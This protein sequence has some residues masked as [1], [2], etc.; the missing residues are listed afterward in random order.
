MACGYGRP[1]C[2][3]ETLLVVD[4]GGGTFDVSILDGF[5]GILE[6]LDSCGDAFLGGDDITRVIADWVGSEVG[7]G[8]A[9]PATGGGAAAAAATTGA[10]GGAV[11]AAGGRYD[12][13]QA[14]EA[15]KVALSSQQ[16]A[17]V[18][19]PGGKTV[20][21]SL[22]QLEQ[23]TAG[24]VARMWPPLQRVAAATRTAYA[25][26]LPD[27]AAATS[28]GSSSGSS[29]DKYAPKPRQL[30]GVVLVG[31]ATHMPAVRQFV[32]RLTALQPA[33][34]P[35]PEEAVALGAAVHASVLQGLS[36]GVE[37]MDG[38]YVFDMHARA[39]GFN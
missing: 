8:A 36:S 12:V 38:G 31:S 14:A 37:M 26:Q 21:L 29:N 7:A 18:V 35:R 30:T 20:Q 28:S 24:L 3:S 1:G 27:G 39:T 34:G 19:L 17:M 32:Q 25:G 13:M 5:E 16:S 23:L 9:G 10:A 15:A 22:S 33:A 2:K 11:V 6:V 4:L